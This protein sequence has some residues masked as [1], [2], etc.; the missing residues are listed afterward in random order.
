MKFMMMRVGVVDCFDIYNNY[1]YNS[2][3]SVIYMCIIFYATIDRLTS[4][5]EGERKKSK[6]SCNGLCKHE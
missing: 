1:T 2:N 6:S 3:L 4:G 5:R